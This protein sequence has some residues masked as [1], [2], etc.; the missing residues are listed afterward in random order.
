MKA[1]VSVAT[2]LA[3]LT[4]AIALHADSQPPPD[5]AYKDIKQALGVVPTFV[6]AVP[7]EAVGAAWDEWSAIEISSNTALP[8]KTKELI[9][10]GVAAQIPCR[11]CVYAHTTFGKA[12]GA[13]DREIREAVAIAANT[14]HWST[15]LNGMQIDPMVFDKE[16]KQVFSSTG[17]RPS[18]APGDAPPSPVTDA[19]S[20]YAD[21][22]RTLGLVPSFFKA[23]PKAGIAAAWSQMKAVEMNPASALPGKTKELIGLAVAAQIP[24]KYCVQFHTMAARANGATDGEISEA[25]AMASMTRYW[26]TILNGTMQDE[27]QF[28]REI[29]QIAKNA[30]EKAKAASQASR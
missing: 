29:D 18:A 28:R 5:K 10:L 22:E 3:T 30:R 23:F 16:L 26:S 21:I 25:V 1:L 27:A 19:D 11:Y 7:D 4:C 14:R 20:A 2:L 12:N 6:K 13:S 9:G 24:C 8:G 17:K 15:V